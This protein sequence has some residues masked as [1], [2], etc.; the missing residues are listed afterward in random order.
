M[1]TPILLLA[2]IA[3]ML[4]L[5]AGTS[6]AQNGA[7]Q[8]TTFERERTL[9]TKAGLQSLRRVD[10]RD[11]MRVVPP[12][13]VPPPGCRGADKWAPLNAWCALI[14]DED[15]DCSIWELGL[16]GKIDALL[17]IPEKQG[18]LCSAVNSMRNIY[19]SMANPL[20]NNVSGITTNPG[21]V[22]RV[23]DP[24]QIVRFLTANQIAN[25]FNIAG[26]NLPNVD[27][28]T[29]ATHQKYGDMIYLSLEGNHM[30][31]VAGFP[32]P[33]M[34]NDGAVLGIRVTGWGE[35]ATLAPPGYLV[36]TEAEVD[37]MVVTSQVS[38]P[39]GACVLNIIDLDGLHRDPRGGT[40]HNARGTWNNLMFS[41]E[42]LDGGAVLST[43]AN[44]SIAVFNGAPL[45]DSCAGPGA[46]PTTGDKVG[47]APDLNQ[48]MV[49]SLNGLEAKDKN[50]LHRFI[51]ET[52]TPE[53]HG[54]GLVQIDV[55]GA[56]P[57]PGWVGL[58][59]GGV[60]PCTSIV[61]FGYVPPVCLDN[62]PGIMDPMVW[63][64]PP[65]VLGIPVA[66]N[67]IG[68]AG[69][70]IQPI[71]FDFYF[72]AYYWDVGSVTLRMSTPVSVEAY[73]N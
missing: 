63:L 72:Q 37:A 50:Q 45:A 59:F 11:V 3:A 56:L 47:L 24:G 12:T 13:I 70:M 26:P 55:E 66:P 62:F 35:P 20:G 8:F 58:V 36:L 65:T 38:N 28:I 46:A 69:W 23:Q 61:S 22:F 39:A 19:I 4:L 18:S 40:F 73:L 15:G 43:W 53:V 64:L 10:T 31:N 2:T 6:V 32:G 25:A 34:A 16:G 1:K 67:G 30:V 60:T 48:N 57:S 5:V 44:G 7:L 42:N 54:A 49:H 9:C 29:W 71:H 27:A 33:V 68:S 51:L 21:D 14:G 17:R 41:G 52:P